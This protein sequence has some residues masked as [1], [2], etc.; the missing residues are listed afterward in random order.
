[1]KTIKLT[2]ITLVFALGLGLVASCGDDDS[3]SSTLPPIGGFNS[4]DEIGAS[5]LVAYWPLNGNGTETKSNT[6]PNATQGATYGPAI[7]GD[8][9]TFSNGYLSYPEI[10]ALSTTTGSISISAWV[11]VSNNAP[12]GHPNFFV[13][14]T[15]PNEWAGNVNFMAETGWYQADND[16]LVVKGYMQ[17]K[18]GDGTVNGQDVRN[19]PKPTPEDILDGHVGNANKNAGKWAHYVMTW[20]G[21][22]GVFKVYA[23]GQK[24]SNPKW[25]VRGGGS[26]LMLN[27][28]TP[29]FPMLGSVLTVLPG[30][31]VAESWQRGMDGQMDEVRIWKKAISAADINSLYELEKAGR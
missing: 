13:S 18:N 3:D 8:G 1:M 21:P 27:Y 26:A 14:L 11:K 20:D 9:V 24:I 5:D 29:T 7:K 16:T 30:D 2:G 6:N 15:R 10:P 12:D 23:N 25:E 31:P 28:F 17:I 4:A 22:T 19:S